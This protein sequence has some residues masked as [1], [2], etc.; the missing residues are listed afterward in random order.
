MI[1]VGA[2]RRGPATNDLWRHRA[3]Q[4]VRFRDRLLFG[5]LGGAGLA[6]VLF[7][8]DWW[9]RAEHVADPLLFAGLS[10]A[11]WYGVGRTVLGWVNYAAIAKPVHRTA[12]SGLRV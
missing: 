10:M 4:D 2:P 7:L 8:A 6:A 9:F 1:L 3:A 12:P 11:F 5:V